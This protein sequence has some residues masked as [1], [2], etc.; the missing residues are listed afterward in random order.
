MWGIPEQ[1]LAKKPTG[2]H[3]LL[4]TGVEIKVR[5]A[6]FRG[7][8]GRPIPLALCDEIAFWRS[9]DSANPDTEVLDAIRPAMATIPNS[10][11]LLASSPYA[12]RGAMWKR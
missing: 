10:M 9:E 7:I 2:Q 5:A 3:V 4:R 12:R 1:L 6:T 8:R 11:L